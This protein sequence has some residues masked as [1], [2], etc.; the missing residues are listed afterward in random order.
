MSTCDELYDVP[1]PDQAAVMPTCSQLLASAMSAYHRL[2]TGTQEVD[3]KYRDHGVK[4]T[5]A[6]IADL[7][8]YIASLNAQ[9]PNAAAAAIVGQRSARRVSFGMC[10][11]R[12]C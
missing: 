9:C 11:G 7:K 10:G 5:Q 12:R 4:Y 8:A 6:N 1:C 3:V 2:V